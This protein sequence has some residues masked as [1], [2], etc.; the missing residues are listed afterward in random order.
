MRGPR[1]LTRYVVREV[2]AYTL[3]G[4]AAI[5][6][7]LLARN[8]VRVLDELLGAGFAWSDLGLLVRLLGTM[9]LLYALPVSF[10]FGVL[11]AVGRMAG[12]V[13]IVALRACGVGLRQLA[14]PIAL[15]GALIS[16]G[17]L[18]LSVEVEPAARREMRSALTQLVARGA[19]LEPGRFQRFGDVLVYV[20]AR[21]GDRVQGVVV[22]DRRDPERPLIVFASEGRMAM[23]AS[24]T[25]LTLALE[26]GDIHLDHPES[27]GERDVRISFDRFDYSVDLAALL[28]SQP[29][30]RAK[31]MSWERLRKTVARL[32]RGEEAGKLREDP[33]EYALMM[34]RRVA[35]PVAATLFG[36]VGLPIGMRRTRGARAWGALWCA[37][38]AFSYYGLQ[39]FFGFLAAEGWFGAGFALWLPNLCFAAL[40][41][42]L[43][44]RTRRVGG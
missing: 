44:A 40:A 15:M 2:V 25:Y 7:I 22:S 5:S 10:L 8:L 17:T 19:G 38:I 29:F 26:H 32:E 41:A 31:E 34:H 43:L 39:T 23:D 6:V 33:I 37:A 27:T 13:E 21:G 20:D 4:L 16:L 1:T 12:D 3:L 11:L 42:F 14:A 30:E 36:L 24:G 35:A 18:W 9:L 28:G